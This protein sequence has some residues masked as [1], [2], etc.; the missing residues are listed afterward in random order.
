MKSMP[1]LSK[2]VQHLAG[3]M[4]VFE[5]EVE[6]C[7]T[8][9]WKSTK[10]FCCQHYCMHAERGQFTNGTPKGWTTSITNC[11]RKLLKIKW[12]DRIPDTEVLKRAGMQSVHTLFFFCIFFSEK[13]RLGVRAHD[14][15]EM[16]SLI[17]FLNNNNNNRMS[18][19]AN[20]F[21]TL[22]MKYSDTSFLHI[23]I[24]KQSTQ[25]SRNIELWQELIRLICYL[26]M[27]ICFYLEWQLKQLSC[28]ILCIYYHF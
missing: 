23:L 8:Q 25:I 17:L 24:L 28:I 21:S 22:R 9:S 11:L 18:S 15:D 12:Q 7:L 1:G 14:S 27:S 6:S 13:I 3:Y 4:V 10:R 16:L 26:I 5:I 2:L 20:M 19:V